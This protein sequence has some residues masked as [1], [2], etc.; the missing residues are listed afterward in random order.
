MYDFIDSS[1]NCRMHYRKDYDSWVKDLYYYQE[2]GD[3][4]VYAG[5]DHFGYWIRLDYNWR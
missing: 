1:N 5:I 3:F 4:L 2:S